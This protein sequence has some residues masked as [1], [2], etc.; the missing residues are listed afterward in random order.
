MD[1]K[2]KS[3]WY[4]H[5]LLT[6][7]VSPA[8]LLMVLLSVLVPA[9]TGLRWHGI[10]VLAPWVVYGGIAA[11]VANDLLFVASPAWQGGMLFWDGRF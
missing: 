10:V 11:I 3:P 5:K 1:I 7:A 9:R 6:L 4:Q 2:H 8:S